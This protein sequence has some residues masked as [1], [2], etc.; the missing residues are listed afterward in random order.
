MIFFIKN[1]KIKPFFLL[2]IEVVTLPLLFTKI[3]IFSPNSKFL[4]KKTG[5]KPGLFVEKIIIS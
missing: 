2:A 1:P 5:R 4:A 3:R